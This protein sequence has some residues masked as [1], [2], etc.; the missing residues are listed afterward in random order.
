M[1]T[2]IQS[3]DFDKEIRDYSGGLFKMLDQDDDGKISPTDATIY[4]DLFFEPCPDDESA[5]KKFMAIFN[6]LD[7]AKSGTLSKDEISS[8]ISK[9]VNFYACAILLALSFLDF[10]I[11]EQ[12]GHE[13]KTMMEAYMKYAKEEKF[14]E[15]CLLPPAQIN[16]LHF[17]C[18]GHFS[19]CETTNVHICTRAGVADVLLCCT[20]HATSVK[21]MQ[22]S[23]PSLAGHHIRYRRGQRHDHRIWSLDP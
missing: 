5:K 2:K 9:F 19:T 21:L 20:R 3:G 6:N 14:R 12:V 18:K 22:A 11:G 16:S 15:V 1:H 13:V 4:T 10:A 8:F 7:L 17:S 23:A